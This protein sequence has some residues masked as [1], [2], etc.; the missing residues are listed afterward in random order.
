VF[1]EKQGECYLKGQEVMSLSETGSNTIACCGLLDKKVT[2]IDRKQGV[3]IKEIVNYLSM[4]VES[5]R[6]LI[7]I[8]GFDE[9]LMPFLL[10]RDDDALK[11]INL[12]EYNMYDFIPDTKVLNKN[13]VNNILEYFVIQKREGYEDE[14]D[15]LMLEWK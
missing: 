10:L 13:G 5:Q 8:P 14:L 12:K 2:I 15:L 3:I 7:P 11:I 4:G 6:Q 9:D 1:K